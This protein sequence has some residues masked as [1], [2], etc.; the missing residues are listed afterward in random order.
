MVENYR[1]STTCNS[2]KKKRV[3]V[4]KNPVIMYLGFRYLEKWDKSQVNKVFT[5]NLLLHIYIYISS[6][7]IV[8]VIVWPWK[9]HCIHKIHN[10]FFWSQTQNKPQTTLTPIRNSSTDF[11][12]CNMSQ[13]Y[14]N[15]YCYIIL[16]HYVPDKN[17]SSS[18]NKYLNND[19]K[20]YPIEKSLKNSYLSEL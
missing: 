8:T 14:D 16:V 12:M 17:W 18:T 9:L 4:K 13:M 11:A 15:V 5:N 6:H 7:F 10:F 19:K 2:Y 3:S 20:G 1:S